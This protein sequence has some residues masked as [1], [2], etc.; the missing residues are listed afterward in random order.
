[1]PE[2]A[3][4]KHQV[5]YQ[6]AN[7]APPYLFC[8][9]ASNLRLYLERGLAVNEGGRKRFPKQTIFLDG[10]YTGAPFL[11]NE[12]SQYSLDHH[13]GCVRAFTLATCEQAV[14]MLLEGLPLDEGEW[15]IYINEPDLDALLAAWILFNH[16]ELLQHDAALLWEVMSFIRT[17]GVIDAHGF[18]M[19]VFAGAGRRTYEKRKAEI[20]ALLAEEKRLKSTGE[21]QT[22]YLIEY[23]RTTFESLD[24]LL[25]PK[26]QL[27]KLLE[28]TELGRET[29]YGKKT[30]M[31]VQSQQGIYL[32]E[33]ELKER[34]GKKMGII[35]LDKG[36][37]QFTIR[38]LDPF[39]PKSL[40]QLYPVLNREDPKAQSVSGSEN[41][42]GGSD[43]IGGSPRQTGSGL[44][45]K[46]ILLLVR[47]VFGEKR[48]IK[49]LFRRL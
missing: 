45:G 46:E 39:F 24:Q 13:F 22:S 15:A 18:D 10:V 25:F 5:R 23:C 38:Q 26:G 30:A 31:L 1:M 4:Q 27:D 49:R 6:I 41:L 21:W 9:N 43:D 11:D 42:W 34:Y 7:E 3:T 17:E 16:V 44:S 33:Q 12:N 32:V 47:K 35:I 37:G 8:G 28:F 14:V 36:G 19:G 48:W 40:N 2:G 29:I 20:D